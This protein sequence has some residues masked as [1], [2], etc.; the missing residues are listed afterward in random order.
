MTMN[1]FA[2]NLYFSENPIV[3]PP[4]DEIFDTWAEHYPYAWLQS[5]HLILSDPANLDGIPDYTFLL[6]HVA[7]VKAR[8]PSAHVGMY[9]GGIASPDAY[10]PE[11]QILA[12]EDL[13][14]H[15]DGSPVVQVP[16]YLGEPGARRVRIINLSRPAT[17]AKLIAYWISFL[18]SNGL[19]SILFD[20]WQPEYYAGN[21]GSGMLFWAPGGT[22]EGDPFN[23]EWWAIQF[24]AYT[25][26]MAA[27]F[28]PHGLE[29]WANGI[30]SPQT[31]WDPGDASDQIT[32]PAQIYIVNY[33]DGVLAEDQNRAYTSAAYAADFLAQADAV[34]A[35]NGRVFYNIQPFFFQFTDPAL[36]ASAAYQTAFANG[37]LH[38]WFNCLFLLIHRP[39]F[40][41]LEYHPG[42][43]YQGYTPP[44][45]QSYL[46]DGGTDWDG[47]LGTALGPYTTD[48]SG[49][50]TIY[51]REYENA[52]VVLNPNETE[53]GSFRVPGL[54]RAW[55]AETGFPYIVSA[56]APLVHVP[57][58][59][60]LVLY[61]IAASV[62]AVR[63][64][65]LPVRARLYHVVQDEDG[66]V[67]PNRS[68][69]VYDQDGVSALSQVMYNAPTGGS[70]VTA[71]TTDSLGRLMLHAPLGERVKLSVS[72][73]AGQQDSEFT[74]DP[75]DILVESDAVHLDQY[76]GDADYMLT[77]Q[78]TVGGAG[79]NKIAHFM[80]QD[81]TTALKVGP[82]TDGI[83][84][85]L[86]VLVIA[87]SNG[88]PRL[89]AN[90]TDGS[91]LNRLMIQTSVVGGGSDL[92]IMP[93][94]G[95][96]AGFTAWATADPSNSVA[97][98]IIDDLGSAAYIDTL[99]TGSLAANAHDLIIRP[100]QAE[101][102]RF[103][104]NG[105]VRQV[106]SIL[107]TNAAS[108]FFYVR[109]MSGT[110]S[111]SPAIGAGTVPM[112]F[113]TAANKLW[114]RNNTTWLSATFA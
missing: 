49:G 57:A 16:A 112:V 87:N 1:H 70:V 68:V 69:T 12:D 33:N 24:R 82:V 66:N 104:L 92:G 52:F 62:V 43:P 51:Y 9:V 41:Y 17:R 106:D 88:A 20:T 73:V 74:V 38:R 80:A 28:E 94:G 63:P 98:R 45:H 13:L 79:G 60:G 61:K 8:N 19:D 54:Y 85:T 23:D 25:T 111:G 4:T 31:P 101:A 2:F 56:D 64:W 93:N 50:V 97:V 89:R 11:Y 105:D 40:T 103:A 81:G 22:L 72:G 96:A 53:G 47:D 100:G 109:T 91:Y 42:N 65:R 3:S 90:L 36:Y 39:G 83:G 48:S 113:D 58:R 114:I 34:A 78:P 76:A 102:F 77:I 14:H 18:S 35:L 107:A 44:P 59:T 26:E 7:E 29:V 67:I 32:G 71:P 6:G 46:F 30:E 86:P 84:V 110:P 37:E 15:P 5:S 27:A 95:T 75:D 99:G 108:G 21:T 55:D 10:Y